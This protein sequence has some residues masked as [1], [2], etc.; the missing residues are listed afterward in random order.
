MARI[1]HWW[2][3]Y[4]T[5]RGG[6]CQLFLSSDLLGKVVT[7]AHQYSGYTLSQSDI[8]GLMCGSFVNI[9]SILLPPLQVRTLECSEYQ[10]IIL[11]WV[12]ITLESY[13]I[14]FTLCFIFFE[15]L[16]VNDVGLFNFIRMIFLAAYL[17]GS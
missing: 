11:A 3:H 15:L 8:F 16:T 2:H 4:I 5:S 13:L 10:W 6:G 7:G 12:I 17:V 14:F 9:L 1:L